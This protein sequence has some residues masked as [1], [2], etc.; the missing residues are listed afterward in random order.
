M[1]TLLDI[2]HTYL[3]PNGA[4]VYDIPQHNEDGT[5]N[6][7][8]LCLRAGKVTGSAYKN[9]LERTAKGLPTAKRTAYLWQLVEESLTRRPARADFVN[10]AMRHGSETE[11]YARAQWEQEFGPMQQVGIIMHP[12]IDRMA[13]S[14]DGLIGDDGVWEAKCPTSQTMLQ[15]LR[16]GVIPE[17]HIPQL[18]FALCVTGRRYV[19]FMAYDPRLPEGYD[20]MILRHHRDEA[21]MAVVEKETLGFL[22][23]VDQ[24]LEDLKNRF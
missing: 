18:D 20:R 13:F 5:A 4:K 19:D 8:W 21:A 12:T 10:D 23:E 11:P 9:I 2:S 24:I 15:W 3:L 14:P 6:I 7:E 22:S 1:A 17:Q 16:E